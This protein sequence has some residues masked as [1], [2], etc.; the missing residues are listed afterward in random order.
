M[1]TAHAA[2]YRKNNQPNRKMG[3][4]SKWTFVQRRHPGGHK[5]PKKLLSITNYWR[6]ANLNGNKVSPHTRQNVHLLKDLQR[7]NVPEGAGN[8]ESSYT[9]GGEVN[10]WVQPWRKTVWRFLK[11][12]TIELP[13]DLASPLL[14]LDPE[15]RFILNDMCTPLFRAALLTISKT[16]HQPKCPSTEKWRVTSPLYTGIHSAMK[17][18][19]N[20]PL[21][22]AWMDQEIYPIGWS[23]SDREREMSCHLQVASIIL[24]K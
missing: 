19:K 7:L 13:H 10:G 17:K 2:Q 4:I 24:F 1:P 6:N 14:A 8:R 22:T 20:M 15:G 5:A 18:N 16:E 12:L 9:V 23:L 11:T 21:A 3:Q